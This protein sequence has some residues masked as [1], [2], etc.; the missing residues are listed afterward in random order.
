MGRVLY[1]RRIREE[2]IKVSELLDPLRK[3]NN[4]WSRA[5]NK[6]TKKS[7]STTITIKSIHSRSAMTMRGSCRMNKKLDIT[8]RHPRPLARK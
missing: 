4:Y 2:L 8:Q 1:S 3:S 7:P 6:K 5:R